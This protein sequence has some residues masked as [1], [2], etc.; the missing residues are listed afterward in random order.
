MIAEQEGAAGFTGRVVWVRNVLYIKIP[1]SLQRELRLAK[2]QLIADSGSWGGAVDLLTPPQRRGLLRAQV[3][4]SVCKPKDAYRA[5][6]LK[7]DPMEVDENCRKQ[8]VTQLKKMNCGVVMTGDDVTVTFPDQSTHSFSYAPRYPNR[9]V[10][11]IR[12]Y[13]AKRGITL[14]PAKRS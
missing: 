4:F 1:V 10:D 9:A 6:D 13:A 14:S 2:P 7:F 3:T 8:F 12:E 5:C 11:R